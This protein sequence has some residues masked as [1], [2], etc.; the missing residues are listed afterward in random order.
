MAYIG[1]LKKQP[2]AHSFLGVA[3]LPASHVAQYPFSGPLDGGKAS[4]GGG[5]SGKALK[6]LLW[7]SLRVCVGCGAAG[8]ALAVPLPSISVFRPVGC[9]ASLLLSYRSAA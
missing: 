8:V 4:G 9:W 5:C 7:P 1:Q 3:A 6:P 2:T